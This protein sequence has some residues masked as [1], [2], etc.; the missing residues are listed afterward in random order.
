[1]SKN[2]D[3]DQIFKEGFEEYKA[4]A[5]SGLEKKMAVV[6]GVPFAGGGSSGDG[7]LGG[8]SS[9]DGGLGSTGSS[10]SGATGSGSVAIGT[11]GKATFFS[12]TLVTSG[13]FINSLGVNAGLLLKSL[14]I[15]KTIGTIVTIGTATIATV[16]IAEEIREDKI[17]QQ[18]AESKTKTEALTGL[19]PKV[20]FGLN[21][22]PQIKYFDAKEWDEITDAEHDVLRKPISQRV[23]ASQ[24]ADKNATA[25]RKVAVVAS[26]SNTGVSSKH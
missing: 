5:D 15:V 6:L 11:A 12:K 3:I 25:T 9:S 26:K 1:M 20:L 2:R 18:Q 14:G 7:N 19:S 22:Y 4:K 24:Q 13:G 21:T 17:I 23:D 10:L 16:M 8:S